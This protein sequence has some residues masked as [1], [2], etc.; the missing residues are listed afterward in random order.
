[1][2]LVLL[3]TTVPVSIGGWGVREGA[4]VFAFGLIGVSE[5]SAFVLSFLFGLLVVAVSLPG[6]LIWLMSGERRSDVIAESKALSG[7]PGV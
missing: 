6:G 4:M 1:M 5:H 7:E 3:V 2:P